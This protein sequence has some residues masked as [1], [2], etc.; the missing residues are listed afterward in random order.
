MTGISHAGE[1]GDARV[2]EALDNPLERLRLLSGDDDAIASFLDELDVSSPREREM[3][4][5]LA[6]PSPLARPERFDN[7]HRRAIEA[8][9]SLRRHGFHGSRAASSL[10]P[11]RYVVRW[12]IGLVARY[13]V[14]SYVKDVVITMRNLYWVREMEAPSD[15]TEL[16]LLRPAR[17]DASALVEIMR[18]REIGVPSFVIAG[19]LIPLGAT[20]WRLM[21]GFTFDRWWVALLVGLIGV[22][23]GVGLS[24]IVLRGK[25]D[26]EQAD[27]AVGAR[28]AERRVGL[29]RQLRPSAAG[30]LEQ[31]RDRLDRAD[32]GRLD[33][34]PGARRPG[35]RDLSAR[36][37]R[38]ADPVSGFGPI[39][40][41]DRP[42]G[43]PGVYR[44]REKRCT[45]ASS[46]SLFCPADRGVTRG[47][48]LGHAVRDVVLEQPRGRP[49]RARS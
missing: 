40:P 8:L 3:L 17:F 7:D 39:P 34:T 25:R 29:R 5:E 11:F 38:N 46:S 37:G 21:T 6:R 30:R 12:L 13:L 31:V 35:S 41:G 47:E 9:E 24:W 23:V 15:S 32:G 36:R 43:A 42:P 16:K 45:A 14:V 26:G 18:S 2:D 49:A 4:A 1:P 33:R 27:P 19:L 28:P 10:G 44:V 20:V 22:A 48:R